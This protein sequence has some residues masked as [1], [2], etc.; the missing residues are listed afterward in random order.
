[1]KEEILKYILDHGGPIPEPDIRNHLFE[2]KEVRDNS[3]IKRHLKELSK[4]HITKIK[5]S[6]GKAN[7]WDIKEIRQLR[8]IKFDFPGILL[9]GY[10]KARNVL[11]DHLQQPPDGFVIQQK[12]PVP[13]L[14]SNG[15]VQQKLT[16]T[17]VGDSVYGGGGIEQVLSKADPR[18]M[19][20]QT[21]MLIVKSPSF[22]DDCLEWGSKDVIYEKW[23]RLY[24]H[25]HGDVGV[26]IR[27]FVRMMYHH[28]EERDVL[29]MGPNYQKVDWDKID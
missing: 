29:L 14:L 3:N 1:M 11:V 8:R 25:R 9:H 19:W 18:D 7:K 23:C 2:T 12:L 16:G 6:P 26:E 27:N 5:G 17:P 10:E 22:F 24:K 28:Y 21:K 15:V 4:R 13:D 20:E